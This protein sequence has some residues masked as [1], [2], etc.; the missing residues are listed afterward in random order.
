M[1]MQN[2]LNWH[3]S[4]MKMQDTLNLHLIVMK[5]QNTLNWHLIVMKMQNTLNWHLI[6]VLVLFSNFVKNMLKLQQSARY[7]AYHCS[8][9]YVCGL[10][11]ICNKNQLSSKVLLLLGHFYAVDKSPYGS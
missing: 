4:V 9:Q 1:K 2:T 6:V 8:V 7:H 3:L 10:S 11:T 5:M